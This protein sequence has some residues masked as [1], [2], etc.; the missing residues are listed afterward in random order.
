MSNGK[1]TLVSLLYTSAVGVAPNENRLYHQHRE[2][3][4]SNATLSLAELPITNVARVILNRLFQLLS[5][6][7]AIAVALGGHYNI[8]R[9]SC[10]VQ[11][12]P[13]AVEESAVTLRMQVTRWP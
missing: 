13:A 7:L 9:G 3:R 8:I 4:I 6:V 11:R 2:R 12:I 5:V 10:P 1:G